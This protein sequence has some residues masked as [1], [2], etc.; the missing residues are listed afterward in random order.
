MAYT[1]ADVKNLLLPVLGE[2]LIHRH[3]TAAQQRRQPRQIDAARQDL[4]QQRRPLALEI[5]QQPLDV[6]QGQKLR[7]RRGQPERPNFHLAKI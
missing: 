2:K 7:R 6:I 3:A 1:A 4:P 5:I